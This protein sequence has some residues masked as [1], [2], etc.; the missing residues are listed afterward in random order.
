MLIGFVLLLLVTCLNFPVGAQERSG[1]QREKHPPSSEVPRVDPVRQGSKSKRAAEPGFQEREAKAKRERKITEARSRPEMRQDSS[2]RIDVQKHIGGRPVRS[3]HKQIFD[4]VRSGLVGG[5]I[6]SFSDLMAPQVYV[7]LRGGESG[8]FS[9][10][11]AYYL[12]ENYLR[13]RKLSG[14]EFTTMGEAESTPY[15]TGSAGYSHK[16]SREI[17]QVYVSLSEVGER[18]MISQIKIY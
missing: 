13:T 18:W 17:A 7:N 1:K 2:K 10:S 9:A 6:A 3:D 8:Y 4:T 15:A 12:L 11:Q 16:G 5:Q 14:L